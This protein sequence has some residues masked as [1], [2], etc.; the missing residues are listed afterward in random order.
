MG[1]GWVEV[2]RESDPF[3]Y[4]YRCNAVHR[5]EI[6]WDFLAKQPNMSDAR[7][8]IRRRWTDAHQAELKFP[9]KAELIKA[10]SGRW[11]TSISALTVEPVPTLQ[12]RGTMSVDGRSRNRNG[13]T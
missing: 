3:K 9:D 12:K 10:S 5:N 1:I 2:A 8:L 11:V 6:W 13:A 7:Y 4:D